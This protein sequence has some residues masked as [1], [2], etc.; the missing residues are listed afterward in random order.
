MNWMLSIM[1]D[2]LRGHKTSLSEVRVSAI[3]NLNL[4]IFVNL[5]IREQ[6]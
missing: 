3:Q 1:R 2:Y 5:P 6:K 4:Y